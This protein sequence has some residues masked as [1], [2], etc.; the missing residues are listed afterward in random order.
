[1]LIEVTSKNVGIIP[2]MP[3][4]SPVNIEDYLNW[5]CVFIDAAASLGS[6]LEN[7]EKLKPDHFIVYSLHATKVLGAGEGS[8]VVCG[9]EDNAKKLCAW[10]NFGFTE[11]RNSNFLATNAKMSEIPAA[12][13]LAALDQKDVEQAEWTKVLNFKEKRLREM[14]MLNIWD[15][16]PGFRPYWI[17][18]IQD[19]TKNLI[20]NLNRNQIGNRTW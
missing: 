6:T 19:H 18:Q 16:Y 20:E 4:G 1:M 14:G 2:V 15:L 7:V 12:Y 3:F 17:F 10:A 5:D 8:I 11:T 9:S 13:A